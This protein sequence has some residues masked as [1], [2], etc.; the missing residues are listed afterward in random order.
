MEERRSIVSA[1]QMVFDWA[2]RKGWL[3][4]YVDI[5]EQVALIHSELS[6]AL[7]AWRNKEQLTWTDDKG[8][9]QGIGS[10]YADAII[11][12]LHYASLLGLDMEYEFERKMAYNEKRPYRHGDKAG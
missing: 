8:K 5:P 9:P 6:E 12:I 4:R 11:R 10:E 1:Q 7:E 2:K 3:D